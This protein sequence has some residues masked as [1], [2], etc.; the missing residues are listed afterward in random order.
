MVCWLVFSVCVCCL[1]IT[2]TYAVATI[3][4]RGFS[5]V[6][7]RERDGEK[8]KEKRD[9]QKYTLKINKDKEDK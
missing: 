9:E 6:A 2:N 4:P 8:E 7:K 1:V 3:T 5:L